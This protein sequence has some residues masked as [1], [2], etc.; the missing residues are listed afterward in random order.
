MSKLAHSCQETMNQIDRD[1]QLE[2]PQNDE[3]PEERPMAEVVFSIGETNEVV[4]RARWLVSR[5]KRNK[6]VTE[7]IDLMESLVFIVEQ[8]QEA[9]RGS[10]K[11]SVNGPT[12]SG[13]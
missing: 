1:W 8:L 2:P 9:I 13:S 6:N 4:H 5:A 3:P 10:A 12:T 11:A 7:Q